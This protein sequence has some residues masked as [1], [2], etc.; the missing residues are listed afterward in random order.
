MIFESENTILFDAASRVTGQLA[1]L[2]PGNCS[3]YFERA[4]QLPTSSQSKVAG[5]TSDAAGFLHDRIVDRRLS[6][7]FE[8]IA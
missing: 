3:R 5:F 2:L 4:V 1:A 7:T 6:Q 8:S